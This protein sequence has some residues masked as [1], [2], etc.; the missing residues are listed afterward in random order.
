MRGKDITQTGSG[1]SVD[2]LAHSMLTRCIVCRCDLGRTRPTLLA[3]YSVGP[4]IRGIAPCYSGLGL[5][6][7]L[8][9]H[10][11][12]KVTVKPHQGMRGSGECIYCVWGADI[13]TS[14]W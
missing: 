13:D 6:L 14:T 3:H 1:F 2:S 12:V 11:H 5:S 4:A 9:G 10:G 7:A 8:C